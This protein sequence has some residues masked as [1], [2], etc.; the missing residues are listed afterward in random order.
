MA[1]YGVGT[2]GTE[3]QITTMFRDSI[4]FLGVRILVFELYHYVSNN[5]V[6]EFECVF[7]NIEVSS[8]ARYLSIRERECFSYVF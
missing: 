7:P 2:I 8:T 4:R 5:N 6:S 1:Y 3:V